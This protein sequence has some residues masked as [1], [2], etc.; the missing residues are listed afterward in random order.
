MIFYVEFAKK[1]FFFWLFT[2]Q[3]FIRNK[4]HKRCGTFSE[5]G[6][7]KANV[8]WGKGGCACKINRNKQGGGGGSKTG[9]FE[10]TYFLNDPYHNSFHLFYKPYESLLV[11]Y[12]KIESFLLC[13][14][15]F[16][17]LDI[18]HL[19]FKFTI[20]IFLLDFDFFLRL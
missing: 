7:T 16:Q 17:L 5:R 3:F 18:F 15:F 6:V 13:W 19:I 4:R 1:I 20:T 10:R 9:S 14:I 12:K 11:V 2:P 8:R